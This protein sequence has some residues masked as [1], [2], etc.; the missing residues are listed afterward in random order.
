LRINV[1]NLQLHLI[2][3][4]YLL[5]DCPNSHKSSLDPFDSNPV[6]T[7]FPPTP[8]LLSTLALLSRP[9]HPL[10]QQILN[11][12]ETDSDPSYDTCFCF[13][14]IC[15]TGFLNYCFSSSF[16]GKGGG[17][18]KEDITCADHIFL[19]F[20]SPTNEPKIISLPCVLLP[21]SSV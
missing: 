2:P 5:A 14:T 10:T 8:S 19:I 11:Q 6:L 7:P 9:P 16:H 13:I 18:T 20:L 15:H 17:S 4:L 1:S 21:Y 12:P 3:L